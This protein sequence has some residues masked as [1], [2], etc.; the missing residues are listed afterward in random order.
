M[1]RVALSVQTVVLVAL[2]AHPLP[3]PRSRTAQPAPVIT[4]ANSLLCVWRPRGYRDQLPW[5][6]HVRENVTEL[7][8][9]RTVTHFDRR[10]RS[11]VI[12]AR[13][14]CGDRRCSKAS[15]S[16]RISTARPLPHLL[17]RAF[18]GLGP[19]CLQEHPYKIREGDAS[20][21][22]HILPGDP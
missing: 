9:H 7:P 19:L 15:G 1:G 4:N 17:E 3:R 5:S 18:D 11:G 12:L 13:P 16:L 8:P 2:R 20:S 21:S 14:L 10:P 6:C 22:P